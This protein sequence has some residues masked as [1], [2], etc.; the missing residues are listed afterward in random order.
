MRLFHKMLK[1]AGCPP[2]LSMLVSSFISMTATFADL[3]QFDA[4]EPFPEQGGAQVKGDVTNRLP[5]AN[6]DK[7]RQ[8]RVTTLLS[9]ARDGS[10]WENTGR[11]CINTAFAN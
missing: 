3:L 2:P 8:D 10:Y 6:P 7:P 11:S 1:S 9:L 4:I 5:V